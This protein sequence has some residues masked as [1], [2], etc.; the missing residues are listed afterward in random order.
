MEFL[1]PNGNQQ[2]KAFSLEKC[3]D[4]PTN[5]QLGEYNNAP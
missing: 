4:G 5:K 1:T 3:E 2:A